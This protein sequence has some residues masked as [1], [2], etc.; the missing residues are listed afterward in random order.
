[1]INRLAA[2]ECGICNRK[3]TL[4]E[5]DTGWV[6]MICYNRISLNKDKN[7]TLEEYREKRIDSLLKK[8]K[9]WEIFKP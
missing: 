3:T 1:M 7:L 2:G 5:F 8:K 6:C 4:V 9:W